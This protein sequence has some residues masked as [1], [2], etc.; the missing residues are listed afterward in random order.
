[1]IMRQMTTKNTIKVTTADR[2]KI[3]QMIES[4]EGGRLADACEALDAELE[5]A[6]FVAPQEIPAD[7]VT[8]NSVVEYMDEESGK[9]TKV[10][11]VY[12]PQ[13]NIAEGKISV[14]APIGS[15]LLGLSVG[16]S[17]SWPLPDGRKKTV[18]VTKVEYQPEAMGHFHL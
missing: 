9:V 7:V 16:Q 17:L 12:P 13:A 4:L 5:R 2:E 11:L 10:T 8:M 1:M 18:R 6:E 3:M 15:A 14:L